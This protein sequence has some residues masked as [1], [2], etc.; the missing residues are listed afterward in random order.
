MARRFT[1]VGLG[2][3]L[4][5]LLPAGKQLGGAPTNFAYISTLLGDRGIVASRVGDDELGRKAVERLRNLGM[6]TSDLQRDATYPTGT[7]GVQLGAGGQPRFTIYENV[8]WDFLSWTERWQMLADDADAVC[9]GTLAQRSAESRGTIAKFLGATRGIRVFDVNL[10]QDFYTAEILRSSISMAT[11]VKMNHD[12]LP[13]VLRVLKLTPGKNE[14]SAKQLLRFGPKLVCIT[15]GSRGSLLLTKTASDEHLGFTV[16]VR[17][18]IG[19]GDAFTAGLVHEYLRSSS[20]EKMN[21]TANRIASWVASR[22]GGTPVV[23]GGSL[24]RALG[25]LV[26]TLTS[27]K[28]L[29]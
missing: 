21:D 25:H 9:F 28:S 18:T 7:V 8:A 13:V 1:I 4:W 23:A 14:V 5:D 29:R 16:R 24:R 27:Q 26:P 15:R 3:V 2:E 11:I 12:E 6:K 19:A 17:D 10:R 22:V 20:L